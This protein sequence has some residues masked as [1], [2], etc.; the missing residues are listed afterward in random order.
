MFRSVY[1]IYKLQ[2]LVYARYKFSVQVTASQRRS[3]RDE[4]VAV[5]V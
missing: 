4:L 2:H 3:R 5:G 1:A